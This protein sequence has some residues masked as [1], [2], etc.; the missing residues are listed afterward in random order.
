MA[1]KATANGSGGTG[2][3]SSSR[4]LKKF[5]TGLTRVYNDGEELSVRVD[6]SGQSFI[7]PNGRI[8]IGT[9][10]SHVDAPLS[11]SEHFRI[12]NNDVSHE[13][14][15]YRE[16][17]LSGI[18]KFAKQYPVCSNLASSVWNVVED[19]HIDEQRFQR[20]PQLRA[21]TAWYGALMA[22]SDDLWTP[23]NELTDH[24]VKAVGS[25]LVQIKWI[26]SP[27]GFSALDPADDTESDVRSVLAYVRAE[28]SRVKGVH[29][30]EDRTAIAHG[31]MDEILDTFP[32]E[33]WDEAE[34]LLDELMD[35]LM[36]ADPENFPE[37]MAGDAE[38]RRTPDGD[39]TA[40]G[41]GA[42]GSGGV[43][44]DHEAAKEAMDE[45]DPDAGEADEATKEWQ[46][47]DED[48]D[49]EEAAEDA[50]EEREQR[51]NERQQRNQNP[52][53]KRV[54][55][56]ND[57]M[58]RNYRANGHSDTEARDLQRYARRGGLI[59]AIKKEF[60]DLRSKPSARPSRSGARAHKGN[61]VRHASG[62]KSIRKL[63]KRRTVSDF[64]GRAVSFALDGSG[65]MDEEDT[66]S[67]YTRLEEAKIALGALG[68]AISEMGDTVMGSCFDDL[69]NPTLVTAPDEDFSWRHLDGVDSTL[70]STPMASGIDD[71][72]GLLDGVNEP[73]R[74]LFVLCDGEP[75][76][77]RATKEAIEDAR[78]DGIDVIGIGF[79]G[80]N[81]Y[82]MEC[83]FGESYVV[84]SP[85]SLAEDVIGVYRDMIDG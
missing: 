18:K 45:T 69:Y 60:Q 49:L 19:V 38:P 77:L 53:R 52:T 10:H 65:S 67:E 28:L 70:G 25:G 32:R 63:S 79:G 15:H 59:D 74:A 31:I 76:D 44:G 43:G 68:E 1:Q 48:T 21:V 72:A 61:I 3:L 40:D 30:Q 57:V 54:N 23:V 81:E 37:S 66:E 46:D 26:G 12:A 33:E 73:E 80:V 6:D 78:N 14:E 41:P 34:S 13:T 8:T 2:T 35:A 20:R 11:Q 16:T 4:A 24:P 5:L 85:E 83:M 55:A 56:R 71:A 9:D 51:F 7:E 29:D 47:M 27:K 50:T 42:P 84:T 17:D 62:N 39:G 75:S 58:D 36:S 22:D 82:D 64:G